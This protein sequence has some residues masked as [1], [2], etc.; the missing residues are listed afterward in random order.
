VAVFG[1]GVGTG[2][3]P[4]MSSQLGGARTGAGQESR[5]AR[6]NDLLRQAHQ[7]KGAERQ[8]LIDDVIV[9]NVQVAKSIARK[10]RNRGVPVEDLEQVACLGLVRAANRFDPTKAD[11]F[12]AYAVPTIRGEVRRHFRDKGWAIRP[13]R[14]IQELQAAMNADAA[15]PHGVDGATDEAVAARLGVDVEQ[16]R[17]AR[18]AQGCFSPTSIDTPFGADDE[19]LTASLADDEFDEHEAVEARVILRTLT[20]ELSSRERL[21]LYLRFVEGRTQSEI[22]AEIGVTQMQVSRLLTRILSR[23]R[24]SALGG[25]LGG[26]LAS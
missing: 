9:E 5:S 23:M 11:D 25:D 13:P 16:V 12:L 1:G 15:E 26:T 17:E 21:I 14:A 4:G 3:S 19:P 24:E 8:S 2:K 18:A 7:A 20:R 10:Y 6:T 22:G